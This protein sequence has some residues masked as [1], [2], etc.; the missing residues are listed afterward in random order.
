M[1]STIKISINPN[2]LQWAREESGF[3]IKE[4]ADKLKIHQERYLNWEKNG[5]DIPLG[6][7]KELAKQFKRQLAIFFLPQT[8]PRVKMP[9]DFR[10]LQLTSKG[11]SKEIK[12]AVRRS[13][14]YLELAREIRGQDYWNYKFNWL[15]DVENI[16]KSEDTA[17]DTA[18]IDWLRLKLKIDLISQRKFKNKEEAFKV[19]RRRIEEELG[20]F[21]FQFPMSMNELHGFCIAEKPPYAVVVNSKHAPAGKIFTLFHEIAHILKNESGIC[22]PEVTVLNTTDSEF[23]CNKF[24]A[25]FLV[26]EDQVYPVDNL[27]E[28]KEYAKL[29]K[30]SNEVYLRRN[31]ELNLMNK[32]KFFNLLSELKN[33]PVKQKKGG[34]SNPI[35]K[36]RNS[37]GDM[38]FNLIMTAVQS[39]SIN[40][41]TASDALGLQV[42][43][44]S[45]A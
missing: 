25:S 22:K 19:W 35:N 12:L 21:V 30:V 26:P 40:Y 32:K 16:V 39:N 17:S 24:A 28:L 41:S 45:N 7:L 42:N 14:K 15:N 10:N 38:F 1:A 34:P 23:G 9:G 6:K 13:H 44:L 11:L 27:E 33:Q 31:L 18:S 20:I 43:Y 37:R 29:L 8:P 36:S 2:L 5:T 3:G 4:I